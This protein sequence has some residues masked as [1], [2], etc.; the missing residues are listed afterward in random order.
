MSDP[1]KNNGIWYQA[2]GSDEWQRH[3]S[4]EERRELRRRAKSLLA[5]ADRK[6][7]AHGRLSRQRARDLLVFER[8]MAAALG[9]WDRWV[10]ASAKQFVLK[11]QDA[12]EDAW[13]RVKRIMKIS[14]DDE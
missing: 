2:P 3:V 5:R 7:A 11:S 14:D 13:E 9:A 10:E 1:T 4:D 8:D 12:V 6:I